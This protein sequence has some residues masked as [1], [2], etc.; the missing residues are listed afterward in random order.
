MSLRLPPQNR[1]AGNSAL[2]VLHHVFLGLEPQPIS[3]NPTCVSGS[4]SRSSFLS[5]SGSRT[6]CP[7]TIP[8]GQSNRCRIFPHQRTLSLP[9]ITNRITAPCR[10]T[11]PVKA[12]A[13]QPFTTLTRK[14]HHTISFSNGHWHRLNHRIMALSR[15]AIRFRTKDTTVISGACMQPSPIVGQGFVPPEV[16]QGFVP[17]K[18][19]SRARVRPLAP[20]SRARARPLAPG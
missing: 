13:C 14:L 15:I 12:A 19:P 4:C 7:P 18:S 9:S 5:F 3:G 16:G 8:L 2:L 1:P 6:L 20:E 17:P 11:A 10:I